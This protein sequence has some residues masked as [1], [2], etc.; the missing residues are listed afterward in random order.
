MEFVHES[1]FEVP[2]EALFAFHERA[3]AFELLMPPWETVRNVQPAASLEVGAVARLEQRVAPGIWLEIV[4]EHVGYEKD[5]L[6]V[7]EMR[8]GPFAAW[9]H[10]HRFE[11]HPE[12]STLVDAITYTP[13]MGVLGRIAAPLAIEPRLRKMFEYRHEV[14]RKALRAA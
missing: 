1:V 11:P 2:V 14:T 13:P 3:D 10:E 7:D 9:R 5:R 4:A 12:G 8:K 6:F